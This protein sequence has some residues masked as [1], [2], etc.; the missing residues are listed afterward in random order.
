MLG[1]DGNGS[2]NMTVIIVDFLQHSG[3]HNGGKR[4]GGAEKSGGE[5]T[6]KTK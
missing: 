4:V 3:G 5:K 2:D 6:T 1:N